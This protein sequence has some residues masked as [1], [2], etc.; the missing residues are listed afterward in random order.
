MACSL[1]KK[2]ERSLK[3]YLTTNEYCSYNFALDNIYQKVRGDKNP[4]GKLLN[5][6]AFKDLMSFFCL[7]M[8][9]VSAYSKVI[10]VR[11]L[12]SPTRKRSLLQSRGQKGGGFKSHMMVITFLLSGFSFYNSYRDFNEAL[13][14]PEDLMEHIEQFHPG[15]EKMVR[16]FGKEFLAKHKTRES[17]FNIFTWMMH[18]FNPGVQVL[19]MLEEFITTTL[20]EIVNKTFRES[21]FDA[22]YN[23]GK[24]C[25]GSNFDLIFTQENF[26][27]LIDNV[28]V[29]KQPGLE[30]MYGER[31]RPTLHGYSYKVP[32]SIV[33]KARNLQSN[34]EYEFEETYN[35][36]PDIKA[37]R[38]K[39]YEGPLD[40]VLETFEPKLFRVQPCIVKGIYQKESFAR[41]K[42]THEAEEI[43][44]RVENWVD[45]VRAMSA[46]VRTWFSTMLLVGAIMIYSLGQ[47]VNEE[48][49][50]GEELN[51]DSPKMSTLV[52][53]SIS[54]AAN[55]SKKFSV[56]A[57][58]A[59]GR[60]G[61]NALSEIK[62]TVFGVKRRAKS[63]KSNV[64][65]SIAISPEVKALQESVNM[66]P[67][68]VP[69]IE[70]R[71]E[72]RKNRYGDRIL[73]EQ[74]DTIELLVKDIEDGTVEC[75]YLI[76]VGPDRT[77]STRI[78]FTKKGDKLYGGKYVSLSGKGYIDGFSLS[79]DGMVSLTKNGYLRYEENN[80]R[81]FI[82]KGIK[83]KMDDFYQ[84]E[85]STSN[86]SHPFNSYM[87][88]AYKWRESHGLNRFDDGSRQVKSRQV[89]PVNLLH[90]TYHSV[91]PESLRPLE[92]GHPPGYM[93]AKGEL[94][95]EEYI[96]QMD[97]QGWIYKPH[98]RHLEMNPFFK[99]PTLSYAFDPMQRQREIWAEQDAETA[100]A[101]REAAARKIQLEK[102]EQSRYQNSLRG[103]ALF[104]RV[105]ADAGPT[106]SSW[107]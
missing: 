100:S 92:R 36:T 22:T 45:N 81:Y 85:P 66:V 91:A 15:S 11:K 70:P 44:K 55:R 89:R 74:G 56:K 106:F 107:R 26:R 77:D 61:E 51:M 33:N 48:V 47:K 103:N 54:R 78:L 50:E 5:E 59:L 49:I 94:S 43:K 29:L 80:V 63:L 17:K 10:N 96:E 95:Q 69:N 28:A 104:S 24:F 93:D 2:I 1:S 30:E 88:K 9:K 57:G 8:F 53:N 75:S 4:Q 86:K 16:K 71:T 19:K 32:A 101:V 38:F 40:L 20:S 27:V 84:A 6:Y 7:T 76:R 31:F 18:Y 46:S 65:D 102:E 90:E 25:Y 39:K 62:G 42:R 79:L 83:Q 72:I 105:S 35:K 12:N 37:K 99:A 87:E 3:G 98:A 58:K 64:K 68:M 13:V 34:F 67:N 73:Y 41:D 60:L 52:E 21:L 97:A 23:S 82:V 14:I